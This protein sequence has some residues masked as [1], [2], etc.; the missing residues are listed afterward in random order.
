[1]INM[2]KTW[3]KRAV[4]KCVTKHNEKVQ[5]LRTLLELAGPLRQKRK[6]AA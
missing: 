6:T 3:V 1:M 2:P 5:K 4:V